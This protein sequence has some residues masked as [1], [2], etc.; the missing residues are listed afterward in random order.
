M[1]KQASFDFTQLNAEPANFYLLV[2]APQVLDHTI[3]AQSRQVTAA[4][5]P[6]TRHK[7]VRHKAFCGQCWAL[8]VTTGDAFTAQI[9]LTA[10]A[11]GLRLQAGVQHVGAALPHRSAYG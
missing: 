4:V 5:Q 3:V 2:D 11:D 10:D 1:L 7:G 9:Q 6:R 8:M